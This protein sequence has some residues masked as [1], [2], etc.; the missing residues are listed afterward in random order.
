MRKM[1]TGLTVS[2]LLL[3][4]TSVAGAALRIWTFEASGKT[5]EGEV[6]GF[7]GNAV[8]LKDADGKTFSV[9]I[10]YLIESDRA[11]L[12][13]ERAKQWKQVEVLRLDPAGAAGR[14]QK[15]TVRGAEVNGEVYVEGLP[16][17][18]QGVLNSRNQQAAP[19]ADLSARIKSEDRALQDLKSGMPAGTSG[20]RVYR[21]AYAAQRAQA[22]LEAT[23]LQQARAKLAKLQ[24]AYDD[25]VEKTKAQTMAKMRNTGI[26]Y[27]GLPVW[28]CFSARKP[29]E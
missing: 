3:V 14:Y 15:C 9:P 18:V 26:V 16:A 21:R 27:K 23:D 24:K 4:A 7:A 10:A 13:A 5:M 8:T 28:E 22:N 2:S 29:Q 25:Y 11:Y 1:I 19:M 6:V 12:A 20:N 17:S